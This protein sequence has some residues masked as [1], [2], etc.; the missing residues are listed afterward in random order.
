VTLTASYAGVQSTATGVVISDVPARPV[1]SINTLPGAVRLAWTTNAVGFLL[2]SNNMPASI[3]G[4][5]VFTSNYFVLSTNYV[6][7]NLLD[8]PV[9]FFRLRRP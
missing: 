9:R 5:G 4:W 6:V 7:T 2:E 1:L 3:A 8:D